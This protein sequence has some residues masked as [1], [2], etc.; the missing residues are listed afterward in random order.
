MRNDNMSLLDFIKR[1]PKALKKLTV[2]FFDK[3]IP[4]RIVKGKIIGFQIN[5]WTRYYDKYGNI[6]R[7]GDGEDD[8]IIRE[9]EYQELELNLKTIHFDSYM[10]PDFHDTKTTL[11]IEKDSL[12]EGFKI[13]Q[14]ITYFGLFIT[15]GSVWTDYFLYNHNT[16]Q[17]CKLYHLDT[18]N[19][20][21]FNEDY[22][23]TELKIEL[24][25]GI[26]RIE[27]K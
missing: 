22:S 25:E 2:N 7:Y 3:N 27:L 26:K 23:K 12:F 13:G 21:L 1:K 16:E 24:D 20:R 17:Y 10:K 8:K 19:E 4:L 9:E 5:T 18:I 15:E 6:L 14:T 11:Y